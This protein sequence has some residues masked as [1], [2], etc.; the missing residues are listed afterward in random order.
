MAGVAGPGVLHRAAT[1]LRSRS[2]GSLA[3]MAWNPGTTT[4]TNHTSRES[5]RSDWTIGLALLWVPFHSCFG[6]RPGSTPRG[7]GFAVL[8]SSYATDEKRIGNSKHHT[9]RWQMPGWGRE[10]ASL[11]GAGDKGAGEKGRYIRPAYGSNCCTLASNHWE[12]GVAHA[13]CA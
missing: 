5:P 12:E 11:L 10:N 4:Y 2:G 3:W 13:K 9:T 7:G 6:S 8:T 1:P